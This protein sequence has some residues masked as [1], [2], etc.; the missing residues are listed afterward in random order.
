MLV[1]YYNKDILL[2][3]I[4]RA[5]FQLDEFL[6]RESRVE[7]W[8]CGNKYPTVRQ[9]ET[10]ANKLHLPFGYFFFDNPP[11]EKIDFPFFRTMA[12]DAKDVRNVSLNVYETIQIVES[13]QEWLRD[14]FVENGNEPLGFVGK[15][16]I[17]NNPLEV[18]V[19]I[20]RTLNI[21]KLWANGCNTWEEA[22]KYLAEVVEE[23]GIIIS[24]NGVVGNST[25]RQIPVDEC[26]GFVLV[27]DI[28]PFM[29]INN[30]DSKAAQV[31]TIAHELAH[32]WIGESAG[33][34]FRNMNPANDDKE[35]FCDRVAAEFLVPAELFKI[36]WAKS[37]DFQKL[38][39]FFKVSPIVMARRALDLGYISKP[40]FFNFYNDYIANDYHK[41][42][43]APAGGDFYSTAKKR[44]SPTFAA[45]I[46]NGVKSGRLLYKD[47]YS[48]TGMHGDTFNEFLKRV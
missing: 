14:Y 8:L 36:Q 41:R 42:K 26:R 10:I 12:E 17:K 34:D 22:L 16:N 43:E 40:D 11:Q 15:Y 39:K 46:N 9:L 25:K 44:I 31:F 2:W 35:I 29:F 19:D 24:F 20:R 6:V 28:V 38:N 4:E 5:G 32:I 30:S 1:E 13:R 45:H 23:A 47:A 48:L 18:A 27:D 37:H 7:E 33:F 3:G 21:D